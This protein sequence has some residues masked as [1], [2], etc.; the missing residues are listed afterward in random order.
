VALEICPHCGEKSW[1]LNPYTHKHEC[2]NRKT[3]PTNSL[4]TFLT[5]AI[6]YGPLDD[7]PPRLSGLQSVSQ[8]SNPL[9]LGV[10][11]FLADVI[12]IINRKY[13]EGHVCAD[14]AQEVCDAATEQGIRCGYVVISFVNADVAHAIVAFQTDYGL[15]YFEPQ[16]GNEEEVKIGRR[17]SAQLEGVPSDGI[18]SKV[19]I[20]WND[21][22]VTTIED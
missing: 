11:A 1:W 21:G 15:K 4:S 20:T 7:D 5:N 2:M 12:Y 14:F 19:Q 6:R 3:C 22:T 9:L 10:K 13:E 8:L 18:I 17:Y 16:S